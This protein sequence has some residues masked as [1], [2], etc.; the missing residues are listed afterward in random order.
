MAPSPTKRVTRSADAKDTRKRASRKA[1]PIDSGYGGSEE[2]WQSSIRNGKPQQDTSED[3]L[4]RPVG[5]QSITLTPQGISLSRRKSIVKQPK[6][7]P[8]GPSTRGPSLRGSPSKSRQPG[9]P[10]FTKAPEITMRPAD[11]PPVQIPDIH[12]QHQ[13]DSEIS[14][15]QRYFSKPKNRNNQPA[16]ETFFNSLPS[17]PQ[18]DAA[19]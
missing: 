13:A 12:Y 19:Y 1:T 3:P 17:Y 10:I 7:V 14:Q 18:T 8:A 2:S 9:N 5:A 11:K 15:A 4:V 16:L 6:P